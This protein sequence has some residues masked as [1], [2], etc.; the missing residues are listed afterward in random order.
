[1][2]Y[3]PF[4]EE[5]AT[6]PL[7]EYEGVLAFSGGVESVALMAHLH[8]AGVK[9]AAFNLAISAPQPP[10][11]P[12]E[13]WFAKQRIACREIAKYFD[14]PLIEVDMQMTNVNTITK[15]IP[16]EG[17]VPQLWYIAWYL[18]LASVYNPS[19]KSLYYGVNSSDRSATPGPHRDKIESMISLMT[20][21]NKL[22][23]PLMHLSKRE[24]WELIPDDIKPLVL[25]CFSNVCGTC[26]KCLERLNAGIPL[27]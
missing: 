26:S 23:T 2:N 9:F 8:R 4:P 17:Y 19:L 1:M 16:A 15:D 12:L 14:V 6:I 20:G 7:D 5:V 25:T 10:Y 11:G 22:S 24:H 18:G 21:S 13:E 3:Y 27:K